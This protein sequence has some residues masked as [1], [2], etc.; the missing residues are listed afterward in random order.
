MDNMQ[1]V[2]HLLDN[3]L[4]E[5]PSPPRDPFPSDWRQSVPV[6]CG[7]RVTLR[8]VQP[9]D[10]AS[11]CGLL[12]TREVARFIHVPPATVDE[13]E[14][15]IVR[16]RELRLA[17]T[18]VCFAV[19]LKGFDT[20][21]GIFQVRATTADRSIAEWGFALG[22]PFWGTG[23]FREAAGLVLQFVFDVIGVHRLEATAAVR[24]GRGNRALQKMGAVQE[25]V[26]RETFCRDGH[27]QDE[28][29]YAILDAD[30]RAR[31]RPA[32]MTTRIRVH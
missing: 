23:L 1:Y 2:G 25:G 18:S 32:Y 9:S 10:A 14:Q 4:G 28:A 3:A 13:F 30:W 16:A 17:G 12:T 15:F 19:T 5:W 7:E 21:I 26:L 22:S 11:L 29:L 20:A 8:E 31:H 6:L 24:N 27:Y